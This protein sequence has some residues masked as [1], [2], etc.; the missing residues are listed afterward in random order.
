MARP[1]CVIVVAAAHAI[2]AA[3]AQ[4][5]KICILGA[6]IPEPTPLNVLV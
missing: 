2:G 5:A 3:A 6:V 4:F 1:P